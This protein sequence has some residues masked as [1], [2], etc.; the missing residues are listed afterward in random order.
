MKKQ[1]RYY[2]AV[3]LNP[4]GSAPRIIGLFTTRAAAEAAAYASGIRWGSVIELPL[5]G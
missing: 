1:Q 4:R 2:L 5:Q 3:E